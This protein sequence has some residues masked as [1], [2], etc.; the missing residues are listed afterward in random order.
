M[1]VLVT[2]AKGQ[3]GAD[4][5]RRLKAEGIEAA[6]FGSAEL[7]VSDADVVSGAVKKERPGIIIN[8]AAY[9][10]V[11]LAEKERL[12]AFA[13]NAVGAANLARSAK[14]A[15][16]RLIHV[17]TDFVF[18]GSSS[19]PYS[20]TD[21]TNPLGVY[22]ESKLAGEAEIT[23]ELPEHV[24]VRTSWLYG[25]TGQNFVKTMLRL[26]SE[27]EALRVVYD[28]VGTPTWSADL[29][30]VLVDI[31]KAISAGGSP[32]GAYH[33]SNEGVA[34]WFDFTVAI[35]EEAAALGASLK[36]STIDPIRTHEYPTPARRPAYSVMDKAKIKKTFGV[37][38]PH[39]RVSLR[40]MLKEL[41]GG[42]HA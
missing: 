42:T 13:V 6:C 14:E 22:G 10:K 17:S 24:I 15:G 18:D 4:L 27:R 3:L 21:G 37:K 25:V 34:S 32:W 40:N 30:G 19:T 5:V 16:A 23:S 20:E 36:C 26:A 11:D 31:S 39:W 29:A 33:Y 41:Y 35:C 28:Q 9:T 8:C 2:G 1:K 38:V 12:R 7:D